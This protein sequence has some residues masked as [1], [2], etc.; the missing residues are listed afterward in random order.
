M[1]LNINDFPLF[2]FT[3]NGC[4]IL[5]IIAQGDRRRS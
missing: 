5:F 3:M 1:N 2:S 4:S